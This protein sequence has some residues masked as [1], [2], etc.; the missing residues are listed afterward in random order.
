MRPWPRTLGSRTRLLERLPPERRAQ[1][2]HEIS[3]YSLQLSIDS[4]PRT[5]TGACPSWIATAPGWP[6]RP[7]DAEL[8]RCRVF[9]VD[10]LYVAGSSVFPTAGWANPT[11]T[12][13]ALALRLGDH[14][15]AGLDERAAGAEA[16]FERATA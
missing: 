4:A 8:G 14:V 16:P 12:L 5:S 2:A 10:N 1:A 9:G 11:L 6:C 13:L 7:L 15:A 3:D